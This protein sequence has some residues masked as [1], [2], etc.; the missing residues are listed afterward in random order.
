M[1]RRVDRAQ[2]E[3]RPGGVTRP[4]SRSE[5]RAWPISNGWPSASRR[6][7]RACGRSPTGCSARSARPRTQSRTPGCGSAGPIPSEVENLSA[8]LTTI[9]ARVS[10]NMLRSR[11]TRREA[12]LDVH[13]P[14]PIVDPA[15]GT[16]PEHEALLADSV[17]LALLVVLETLSH[18]P[19][20]SRSSC[21]TCS[22]CRSSRSR[23]SSTAPPRRRASWRAALAA[24]SAAPRR[25]RIGDLHAQWE[26][27]EAFLAAA[28]NGRLRGAR[29]GARSRCCAAGRRRPDRISR[30][31]A[32]PRR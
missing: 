10:L 23:R 29:R 13:V 20:D 4:A 19:S 5:R 9:V 15:D 1:G 28:R 16:N 12:P 24:A 32:A 11:S 27:V 25:C 8:W 22:A 3:R 14:D 31:C 21:T 2:P 26:V 30:Q 6:T 18:R 17:G 7:A